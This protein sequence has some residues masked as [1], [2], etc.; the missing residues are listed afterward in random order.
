MPL[1]FQKI[2]P[3]LPQG[4]TDLALIEAAIAALPPVATRK[5][6]DY[7]IMLGCPSG[8]VGYQLAVTV[9]AVVVAAATP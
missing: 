6:V 9:D 1:T 3:L 2:V 7:A 8:S 4:L 5:I